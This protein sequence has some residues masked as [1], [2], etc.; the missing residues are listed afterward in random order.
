[1]GELL[2]REQCM[3]PH[4]RVTCLVDNK[5][6]TN[7]RDNKIREKLS[8]E[9]LKYHLCEKNVWTNDEFESIDWKSYYIALSKFNKS[10]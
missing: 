8:E 2:A 5:L 10:Q 1:M 9:S 7:D 6:T 4:S 3:L